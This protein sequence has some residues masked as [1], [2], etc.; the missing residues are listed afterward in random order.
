[1][2]SIEYLDPT[3]GKKLFKRPDEQDRQG[4]HQPEQIMAAPTL[5]SIPFG[6]ETRRLHNNGFYHWEDLFTPRQQIGYAK[7]FALAQA[8]PDPFC[9]LVSTLAISSTLEYNCSLVAYNFKYRKSHHLF[10]HHAFPIPIQGVEGNLPGVGHKG[11]GTPAN[12]MR[13]V[14]KMMGQRSM[15]ERGMQRQKLHFKDHP[16]RPSGYPGQVHIVNGDSRRIHVPDETFDA[17]ITDPPYHDNVQYGELTEFFMAWLRHY[18]VDIFSHLPDAAEVQRSEATPNQ[19]GRGRQSEQFQD[20]LTDIFRE[21][22]RVTKPDGLLLFSFHDTDE[23][24]WRQL[25]Q[26]LRAAGWYL[27]EFTSTQSEFLYNLHLKDYKDPLDQ[28]LLILC[29]KCQVENQFSSSETHPE[30]LKW[31]NLLTAQVNH[32][33]A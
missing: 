1:L 12:R 16:L 31:G 14:L 22:F 10:T 19:H 18:L 24:G 17:V 8:Q 28:D 13:D 4:F 21:S 23:K 26:S 20:V 3:T 32:H 30:L 9:R 7:L 15:G 29:G 11:A 5:G 25:A 27:W 6:T 2:V 33:R